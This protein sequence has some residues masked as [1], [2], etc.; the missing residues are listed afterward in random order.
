[1]SAQGASLLPWPPVLLTRARFRA[2]NVICAGQDEGTLNTYCTPPTQDMQ[3]L[4][5]V[6][7][8]PPLVSG[9]TM[10]NLVLR[11]CDSC[12]LR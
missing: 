12:I 9:G 2:R 8:A 4:L 10:S 3:G 6:P 7:S 11:A 1:M 5:A